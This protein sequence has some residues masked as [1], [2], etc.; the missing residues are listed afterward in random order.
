[1]TNPIN[2]SFSKHAYIFNELFSKSR[3]PQK[4]ANA[5]KYL[6]NKHTKDAQTICEF[7]CGTGLLLRH[8][9]TYNKILGVD[10]SCDMLDMAKKDTMGLTIEFI[11]ADFMIDKLVIKCS[12][13]LLL[14]SIF[15]T[16]NSYE[17]QDDCL[18][19]IRKY[20]TMD[21][22]LFLEVTNDPVQEIV[23]PYGLKKRRI[24]NDF[25]IISYSKIISKISK[26][27]I[28]EISPLDSESNPIILRHKL[29]FNDIKKIKALFK[30][31]NIKILEIRN[32]PDYSI[33]FEENESLGMLIIGKI[34]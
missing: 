25:G 11:N 19:I 4:Q 28:F 33:K 16:F 15:Q 14:Y 17:E 3:N 5:L 24:K 12:V 23:Y 32:A 20:L 7:G 29:L 2:Q 22:L 6:I 13:I 10:R 27:L 31:N 30:K 9:T 1:M 34:N 21:G 8:L 18:K 26:E